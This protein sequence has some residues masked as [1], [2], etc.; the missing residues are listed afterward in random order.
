M[1]KIFAFQIAESIDIKRFRKDYT[2]HEFFFNSTELFYT[3]E[4]DKYLH[5]LSYGVVVFLG[6]DEVKMS[7]LIDYVKSYSKGIIADKVSEEFNFHETSEA[8]KFTYNE[9]FITRCNPSILR[10]I[11]LNVGQSVALDFF[12]QQ[13][14]LLLEE[15]NKYSLKLEKFGKLSISNKNLLKFIGKTLNFKNR[16]ID[17]L[18]IIDSPDETWEDE[19]L[20]KI[21]NALRNIFDLKI[22]FKEID[23]QLQIIK[24]NLDLFKDLLQ[25]SRSNILEIIIIVLIM[26]EVAN[27]FLEKL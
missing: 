13:T 2:G 17:N 10:I 26:I 11:M 21:D 6:Y 16:I 3:S 8:D 20:H 19:Y 24:E 25:H 18:Y 4:N 9:I 27:L 5:I 1:K 23:Y 12:A 7:E 14:S 22:R 15:T